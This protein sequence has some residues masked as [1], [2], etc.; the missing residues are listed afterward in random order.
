MNL[1][2]EYMI[3]SGELRASMKFPISLFVQNSETNEKR[4]VTVY[5]AFH[6]NRLAV[7]HWLV[8]NCHEDEEVPPCVGH[9]IGR[10][11]L[12]S[13]EHTVLSRFDLYGYN[14]DPFKTGRKQHTD[15]PMASID[16]EEYNSKFDFL[17][18]SKKHQLCRTNWLWDRFKNAYKFDHKGYLPTRSDVYGSVLKSEAPH[19]LKKWVLW[20]KYMLD[21]STQAGDVAG[22]LLFHA[23]Y[24]ELVRREGRTPA[25]P[26]SIKSSNIYDLFASSQPW[27]SYSYYTTSLPTTGTSSVLNW[28]NYYYAG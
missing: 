21:F 22:E 7:K 4:V 6:E 26:V 24:K 14:A 27:T 9:E 28:N 3:R 1:A 13:S 18:N 11:E 23:P 10:D 5:E 17:L 8:S 19:L 25:R 2:I 15:E 12:F 16:E 20:R